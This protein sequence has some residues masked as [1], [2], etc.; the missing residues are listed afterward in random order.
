MST[1]AWQPATQYLPGAMVVP[2]SNN[3]VIQE[4][5]FNNSF[6][7]GLTHWTVTG[8]YC[9]HSSAVNA[10]S[11][12][13]SEAYDGVT[14]ATAAPFA[15]NGSGPHTNDGHQ[16]AFVVFTNDFQAPVK[17]GTIITFQLRAYH[18][19][20]SSTNSTYPWSA[21]ARLAWYDD[22]HTFISYSY[23]SSIVN[24]TQSPLTPGMFAFQDGGFY[25]ISGSGTAPSN[26]A[27]VSAV[28]VIATT[29]YSSQADYL[30]YF[31]WDYTQQGYPTGL[32]YVAVQTG[33]GTSAANEPIWPVESGQTIV[34]NSVTWEAEFASTIT[35]TASSI[36]KSGSSE[37]SWPTAIGAVIS[38]GTIEWTCHDGRITDPNCPPSK[39]VA[40]AS[41]KV[42][43]ADDDIIRF[44]ATA[45]A[46]DWSSSLD[47]GFIPFGLQ[48]F[49]NESVAGMGLYRSNLVAF[50]S[51]GYQMW[52]VDPDPNNI[53]I[54]DAE[55]V[56]CTYAK[57]IQPV[58]NDLVFL[59]PVGIR[60][61]GTAGASG[62]LQAGQF[63]KAIDPIVQGL[64]ARLVTSGYE[65]RSL[66]NPGT[67]QYFLLIGQDVI[68]LSIN[69]NNSMSWSRYYFPAVITDYC[70]LDGVL[71]LRA[72]DLVWEFSTQALYDDQSIGSAGG[73]NVPFDGYMAWNYLE[74]GALGVEKMM[75]GFDITVG[76][77]DDDG[78]ITSNDIAVSITI[79][80]NQSNRELATDPYTVT[81][82]SIPGT[83]IPMPLTAPS[84]QMRLDFGNGQDWGWGALNLYVRPLV[85]P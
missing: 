7:D 82:D 10:A 75:E 25:T 62:N 6:E 30:D 36:L 11:A 66:F 41:A 46:Q 38:D 85:K 80:Y 47:A 9:S 67:G 51:L 3:V 79:G 14:S 24:G 16:V 76:N 70:V 13:T 83:M 35:W 5:P 15:G 37:P 2:R 1:P 55:P 29:S 68:V 18:E 31:T 69:G 72:G 17:P 48:T 52:Q 21:G 22:T 81:G 45:N 57:S 50:N 71:Y 65:P 20:V 49:G 42:Y 44:S 73:E 64:I 19:F 26:A 39:I 84:F 4:Q 8:E 32:V 78:T 12:S 33:A 60:N 40:I 27:Y 61:I 59:S 34:D 56:G 43:A 58:N 74:C 54:L 53:A 28:G 23:A 77:I 63:G